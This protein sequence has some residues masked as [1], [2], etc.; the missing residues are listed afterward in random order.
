MCFCR[1]SERHLTISEIEFPNISK[2]SDGRNIINDEGGSYS[3][4]LTKI[5]C[6]N[7]AFI[8]L[9]NLKIINSTKQII[10]I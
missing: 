9:L 7:Q 3:N 1:S 2:N 6:D 8:T 5:A 4:M 10:I